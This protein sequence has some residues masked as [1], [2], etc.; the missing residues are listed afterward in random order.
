MWP[1]P[2]WIQSQAA[3]F[4]PVTVNIVTTAKLSAGLQESVPNI[5]PTLIREHFSSLEFLEL[6]R[7]DE[8]A[9]PVPLR[10][11]H[12]AAIFHK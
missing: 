6:F 5:G 11:N 3:R 8:T 7:Y 2:K 1:M 9:L 4:V 10:H 12:G